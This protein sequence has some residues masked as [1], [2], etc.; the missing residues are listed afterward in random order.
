MITKIT[1]SGMKGLNIDQPLA[2]RTLLTGP[3]GAGK[4]ARIQTL[5]LA[6]KGY[7]PGGAKTNAEILETYGNGDS[8][9]VG[10]Q[11]G[12]LIME[13]EFTP[14]KEGSVSQ[15]YRVNGAKVTKEAF[16]QAQGKSDIRI[17]DLSAFMAVSD[18]KKIDHV[19]TLYPPA[20]DVSKMLAT[21]EELKTKINAQVAKH[22]SA[23]D[24]AARLTKQ[25]ADMEKPAGTMAEN[26]AEILK[27]ETAIETTKKEIEEENTRIATEKAAQDAAE[28][29][30]TATI[31]AVAKGVEHIANNTDEFHT[32]EETR[33]A[34]EDVV[35]GNV[36]VSET[37]TAEKPVSIE[38]S[39]ARQ[40]VQELEKK[41]T[42][43]YP[44]HSIKVIIKTMEEAGCITCAAMLVAKRELRS[45]QG[46]AQ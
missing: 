24:V 16:A 2:L 22:K 13:R 21:I 36:A 28:A 27:I 37:K 7:V 14:G 23:E 5:I 46:G 32:K 30:T 38:Q 25:H 34:V 44:N 8:L 15:I 29:A 11:V 45:F 6:V 39:T 18:T 19:L 35:R 41:V 9:R 42:E 1:A 4:S 12:D 3:N 10:Y 20:G 31:E 33:Q 26:D 17:L 43:M 40:T